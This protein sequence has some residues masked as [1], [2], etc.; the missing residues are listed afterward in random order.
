MSSSISARRRRYASLARA[1][2]ISPASPS[3]SA[4]GRLACHRAVLGGDEVQ[5]VELP[6]GVGEEPREV[7]HA[8]EVAHSHR[9]PLE[10][11][12]PVVALAT[13]DVEVCGG[14]S[15]RA[16]R[17]STR[18]AGCAVCAASIRSRI[19]AGRLR[20]PRRPGPRCRRRGGPR[21]GPCVRAPPHRGADLVPESRGFGAEPLRRPPRRP[22]R[23]APFLEQGPRRRP[24]PCCGIGRPRASTR[25]R[26]SGLGRC[27]RPRSRSRP[28]PRVAAPV[29][30]RCSAAA[31]SRAP[32]TGRSSASRIEAAA[33]ATS[34]WARRTSARP[35]WGSH[36]AR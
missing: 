12:R 35:G 24:A 17:P 13:K 9:A 32:A 4:T 16:S 26:R 28:A 10:H 19:V 20:A 34:P 29:A 6:A 36:P 15:S 14:S 1:S 5:H 30:G 7:P 25:R 33:V 2:R 27:R 31:P 22:R 11:H 3:S 18:A 23:A 21:R 8:L